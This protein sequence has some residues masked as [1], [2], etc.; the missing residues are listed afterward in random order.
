V[1]ASTS[2]RAI[3]GIELKCVDEKGQAVPAGE[4]GEILVRG[5]NVMAGYLDNPQA[6]AG[7]IDAEGWLHTGDIGVL[8]ANGNLAITDRLKDMFITGGF[9]CYPAEIENLLCSHE[10]IAMAAVIGV[11]DERLGEVAM[12]WLVTRSGKPVP[13]DELTAWSRAHMANYKVPRYFE[14]VEALPTNASGKVLKGELRKLH[15]QQQAELQM[16]SK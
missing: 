9:N 7:S 6:T 16:T 3:P 12:A 11:P 10:Q 5:F 2:G 14:F 15:Q 8:D 4:P 13:V 1:I